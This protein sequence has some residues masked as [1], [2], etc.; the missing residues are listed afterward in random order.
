M[1]VSAGSKEGR[2]ME[3][4]QGDRRD[5]FRMR[6]RDRVDSDIGSAERRRRR[7]RSESLGMA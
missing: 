4:K 2:Q 3:D 1:G 6:T 5:S 7:E